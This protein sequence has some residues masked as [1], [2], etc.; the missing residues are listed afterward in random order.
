MISVMPVCLFCDIVARKTPADILYEDEDLVA[1]RDIRPKYP[2]HVLLVPK[3]HLA[4]AAALVPT[5]DLV[6]GKLLRIGARLAVEAGLAAS[7][8][9]LLTNTGDDAGQVVPHLHMH[10]LGGAPLRGL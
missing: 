9:R 10:L 3:R 6:A 1:F 4:S 7:G 5:L 8:F 2:V